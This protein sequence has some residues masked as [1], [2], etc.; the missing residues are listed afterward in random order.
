MRLCFFHNNTDNLLNSYIAGHYHII[1]IANIYYH[2]KETDSHFS[3]KLQDTWILLKQQ[4]HWVSPLF[5]TLHKWLK[6]NLWKSFTENGNCISVFIQ[7]YWVI[8]FHISHWAHR[9]Q[10]LCH[11]TISSVCDEFESAVIVFS[12][13]RWKRFKRLEKH[14]IKRSPLSCYVCDYVPLPPTRLNINLT[15]VTWHLQYLCWMQII[16]WCLFKLKCPKWMVVMCD[17]L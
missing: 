2:E 10:L 4:D 6:H 15:M 9:L 13:K 14:R 8:L 1:V 11:D 12:T 3:A 16:C 5:I 17:S 7:L